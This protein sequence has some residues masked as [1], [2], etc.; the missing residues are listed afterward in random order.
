MGTYKL[1]L[2]L[3]F[4]AMIAGQSWAASFNR[5]ITGLDYAAFGEREC[6]VLRTSG[7]V[8]PPAA[9]SS[10]SAAAALVFDLPSTGADNAVQVKPT[11]NLIRSVDLVTDPQAGSKL[12]VGLASVELA[13]Q[14]CFRF[15]KPTEHVLLLEIFSEAGMKDVTSQIRDI[16]QLLPSNTAEPE[17]T[18]VQPES[19]T[20]QVA[21]TDPLASIPTVDL[22]VSDPGRA[23]G[24]AAE[25]GLLDAR[26]QGVITTEGWGELAVSPVGQS[27]VNW[28]AEAPPGELL[29]CGTQAQIAKFLAEASPVQVATQPVFQQYWASAQP[30]QRARSLAGG[31]GVDTRHQVR[32]DPYNGLFY[33]STMPG[34]GRLSDIRVTLNATS[35]LN[36]YDVLNYLSNISGISLIIDPYTFDEPTG[37]TRPPYVPDGSSPSDSGPGFRSASEF[38]PGLQRP[39]T[40]RGNIVN[41][42]FDEALRT[43]LST[44][45]L[46]FVVVNEGQPSGKRY[47]S[48]GN[49][50]GSYEKPVILVTSR[51]RLEQELPG[52]NQID[53]YQFHY[54][55]PYQVTEILQEFGMISP[56]GSGWYIYE[57]GGNG[58]GQGGGAGRGTGGGGNGG[59]SVLDSP[60][61]ADVLVF[62]GSSREPV[63]EQARRELAAG[64]AGV[65]VILAPEHDQAFLTTMLCR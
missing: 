8:D 39:G 50:P 43:I 7:G 17:T 5:Q 59:G 33:A 31:A 61:N 62:Q 60:A 37:S 44:H 65:R 48:Q 19:T 13:N 1:A 28:S 3:L 56:S 58:G 10:D 21:A 20:P 32:D 64:M 12:V 35:G 30:R 24:L 63:Y 46:E 53:L 47:G 38:N 11:G 36:L 25:L 26:G 57:G 18:Y 14:Q 55:D 16:E 2:A 4:I 40:V 15:T 29:L 9:F 45:N 23:L 22:S 27:L 51:E 41:M 52:T 6:L 42:P 54:A 49:D 34:G